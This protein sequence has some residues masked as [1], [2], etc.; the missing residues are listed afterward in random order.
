M[1]TVESSA[2]FQPKQWAEKEAGKTIENRTQP[3][4]CPSGVKIEH[5]SRCPH[6]IPQ[7]HFRQEKDSWPASRQNVAARRSFDPQ[8]DPAEL[9]DP[10]EQRLCGVA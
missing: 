7:M 6:I 10:I 2:V 5:C 3:R 1:K 8:L 4:T 9:F